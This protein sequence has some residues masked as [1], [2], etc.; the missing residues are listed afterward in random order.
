MEG[1]MEGR[2]EDLLTVFDEALIENIIT[3]QRF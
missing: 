1:R 2:M 3:I